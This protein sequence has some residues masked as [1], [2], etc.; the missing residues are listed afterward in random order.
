MN[1]SNNEEFLGSRAGVERDHMGGK[2]LAFACGA[3]VLF[4][5]FEL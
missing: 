5:S 1:E 4:F 2:K 3:L